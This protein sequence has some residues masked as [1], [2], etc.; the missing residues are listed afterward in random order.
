MPESSIYAADDALFDSPAALRLE[1]VV[2][3]LRGRARWLE[4]PH[5]EVRAGGCA[6]V[7]G[8]ALGVHRLLMIAR[9]LLPVREGRVYLF[10]Q[11]ARRGGLWQRARLRRRM[12]LIGPEAQLAPMMS[13]TENIELPARLAG[14]LTRVAKGE[15]REMVFEFGL[16]A[17]AETLAAGASAPARRAAVL[18]R[19][20][21]ARPAL[22]LGDAP[23]AGVAERAQRAIHAALGALREGG[24]GM[25]FSGLSQA[26]CEQLRASRHRII[27]GVLRPADADAVA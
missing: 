18:A 12:A 6:H 5:L 2:A 19:A 3:G 22:I 14:R 1:R 16:E 24:A 13:L 10:G 15:V 4:V 9:L 27:D 11:E 21:M 23:F 7:E 17:E 20:V 25:V 8:E 26:E